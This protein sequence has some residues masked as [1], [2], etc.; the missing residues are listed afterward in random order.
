MFKEEVKE[1][2]NS[3]FDI[4]SDS[5]ELL[6]LS[7]KSDQ[8]CLVILCQCRTQI[9]KEAVL[10]DIV[11]VFLEVLRYMCL[12]LSEIV[13]FCSSNFL[14]KQMDVF[15]KFFGV[16]IF[17]IVLGIQR[18]FFNHSNFHRPFLLELFGWM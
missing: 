10:D 14:L 7:P 15:L 4:G 9:P 18:L 5:L 11:S 8:S 13:D 16:W 1:H 12:N 17:N 6:D 3:F 2:K